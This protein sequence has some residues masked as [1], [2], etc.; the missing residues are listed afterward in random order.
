[1][2][3][4]KKFNFKNVTEL[5]RFD[6]FVKYMLRDKSNFEILEGFLSELLK[7]QITIIE[8]IESESNKVTKKDKFNRV[9]VLV[10]TDK[11]ER[12]IVEI[13]NNTEYD[14][15]LRILFGACK[16]IVENMSSGDTYSSV[17]R[18]ISVS[19]VYFPIAQGADYIY[20]GQTQFRGLHLNDAL[21]LS[22]EEQLELKALTPED[23]YPNFYII[24]AGD[25]EAEDI[26]DTLDEWVYFFRTGQVADG[27]S[28]QGLAKAKNKL[29]IAKMTKKKRREYDAYIES[30]RSEASWN[31]TV[32]IEIQKAEREAEERGIEKGIEKGEEI[33][34]AKIVIRLFL[35]G[36]TAEEI[37]D[38]TDIPIEK[39]KKIIAN[40]QAT[41]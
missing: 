7:E 38:L 13:Q 36:N 33:G 18:I 31:R 8:I 40:Y 26:K 19:V 5:V 24:K 25:F 35:K 41:K 6:W 1:M 30:L 39:V 28:A 15:L 11:D 20:L 4:S 12:I 37:A 16:T 22:P 9:D 17:K 23:V 29:D 10:K 2:A 27:F 14:Y 3:T 21:I 34:Q 32:M